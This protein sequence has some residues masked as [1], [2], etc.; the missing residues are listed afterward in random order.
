MTLG[1]TTESSILVKTTLNFTNPTKYSAT[2]PLVVF[3]MLYN[4]TTVAH[5]TAHNVTITPGL[6]P[7][8]PVDLLW[9]PLDSAGGKGV[10]AGREMVS[11]YVSGKLYIFDYDLLI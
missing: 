4:A 7:G 8:V 9:N 2:I 11:Q 3:I 6:N 1:P 10:R 5:I